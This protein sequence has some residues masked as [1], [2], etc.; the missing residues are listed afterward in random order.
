VRRRRQT[1]NWIFLGLFGAA[2]LLFVRIV[3]SFVMP[4]LLGAFLVVL[5]LPVHA[6][7]QRRVTR[8]WAAALTTA[9]V[10]LALLLP[11]AVL[12]YVVATEVGSAS[13]A[14]RALLGQPHFAR[15]L[16]GRL[17]GIW[18]RAA[19]YV[20][21]TGQKMDAALIGL[22]GQSGRLVALL[23]RASTELAADIFLMAVAMYY[24]FLDGRRLFVELARTI[25][26][27]P[28]YLND[29]AREFQDVAHAMLYGTTLT[30]LL[31]GMTGYL[32]LLLARAP[33]AHLF[34]MLM[35]VAAFIPAGGTALVWVPVALYLLATQHLGAGLFLLFW[36]VVMVGLMDNFVR[37][38]LCGARLALHPLLVFLSM[39]GGF[40]VFGVMGIL[41]GPLVASLFMAMVRI[42]RRDFLHL[43]GKPAPSAASTAASLTPLPGALAGLAAQ[44]AGVPGET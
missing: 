15:E 21:P 41:V 10:I 25:P 35:V 6:F 20:D 28:R 16:V 7:L 40:A 29:F 24:L 17:P 19:L 4:V 38:K 18:G 26:L 9:F 5:F 2:L 11:L 12:G 43:N 22:L 3:L 14:G 30:A 42:Y 31:Q 33:H 37:P 32:G 34:A 13:A 8:P 27:E 39:F 44:A 1:S 36:G 23:L